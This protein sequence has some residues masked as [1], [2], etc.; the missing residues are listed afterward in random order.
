MVNIYYGRKLN[1][2][3]LF[4]P[5][6]FFCT[7]F[8]LRMTI[9]NKYQINGMHTLNNLIIGQELR[10]LYQIIWNTVLALIQFNIIIECCQPIITWN[11]VIGLLVH[12]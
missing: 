6:L 8:Y 3:L 11:Q 2:M 1:I 4:K 12:M 9:K 5:P 7:W 10:C